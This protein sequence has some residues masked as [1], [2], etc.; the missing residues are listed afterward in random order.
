V[1]RELGSGIGELLARGQKAYAGN[2]YVRAEQCYKAAVEREPKHAGAWYCLG[3]T[4]QAQG[5]PAQA[6][7]SYR[8][9]LTLQPGH[10]EAH[11][12]LGT[13]LG[14]MGKTKEAVVSLREAIRLQPELA[15]AHNNLG[16]A[17]GK[18]GQQQEALQA[19]QEAVRL[20]PDYSEAQFNYAVA[21]AE[22]GRIEDAMTAYQQAIRARGDFAEAYSNLGLLL[23]ENGRPAEAVIVLKQA[24][25]LSQ[26]FTDAHNNLG[27]ALVDLGRHE[28]A[29]GSYEQALRLRPTDPDLHNNLGTAL[30]ALGRF[31]EALASFQLALWLNPQHASAHWDRALSLLH[32]GRFAEGWQ[33]YEWRWKRNRSRPRKMDQPRWDGASLEDKTILIYCE[34]GL[35]DTLQFL[36]YAQA[37][38]E[39]GGKVI[40]ECSRPLTSLLSTCPGVA[41]CVAE[42]EPLPAHDLQAPL[43]S[44]PALLKADRPLPMNQPYLHTDPKRVAIWQ[45][46][47]EDYPGLKVGIA[48]QG[49]PRHRWDRHRSFPLRHFL[50]V[51][52]LELVQV[53]SLQKGAGAEQ[54]ADFAARDRVVDLGSRLDDDGGLSDVAAVIETLDLVITCDSAL[55]H[56]AGALGKPVWVALA[57]QSDWRWLADRTDSP[58]YPSVR[59]FRQQNR[60]D[61]KEVFA[62]IAGEVSKLG[63]SLQI[64]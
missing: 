20:E 54:L 14:Q 30:A 2:D 19:W 63:H 16:V 32:Q 35:G 55:A 58:W 52:E 11:V 64:A 6:V 47:L 9:V 34:Q 33:E 18:L 42:G 29:L 4:C 53:I 49:N 27:L 5:K 28:E 60:F 59:L 41:T 45:K 25:R 3:L 17:L 26:N 13:A 50:E 44:L 22:A 37:L 10:A 15:K 12:G 8:C 23:T 48:W 43:L 31:D 51:C 57:S 62:R 56:L 40:L 38:Q 39:L 46:E 36:R 1:E 7:E 24:T 21:L 61:W